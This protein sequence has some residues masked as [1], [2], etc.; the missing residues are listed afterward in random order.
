MARA[1]Y[2]DYVSLDGTVDADTAGS[3][4]ADIIA[5]T[6]QEYGV[7]MKGNFYRYN[8][9]LERGYKMRG[10]H[11]FI[12]NYHPNGLIADNN[13]RIEMAFTLDNKL[14]VDFKSDPLLPE[15][16][17][18]QIV[19][20]L[21]QR[22]IENNMIQS[23]ATVFVAK[24]S[25]IQSN[26]TPSNGESKNHRS[27]TRHKKRRGCYI[28]TAVYGSYNCSEVWVLRRFRDNFLAQSWYGR[29]FIRLYY[30]A[31]PA[32]VK[33]FGNTEWFKKVWKSKL[34]RIVA[35]L[36]AKGISNAPYED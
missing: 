28:A 1:Y 8:P 7:K 32:L 14:F 27:T 13:E 3:T 9:V 30:A 12:L 11:G 31:S 35:K 25:M 20:E 24:S 26:T 2:F 6:L 5:K 34:D 19:E 29:I 33:K 23:D 10:F 17:N 15:N 22:L 4:W 18:D 16:T 21:R 36:E